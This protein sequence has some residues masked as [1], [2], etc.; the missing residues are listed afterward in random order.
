MKLYILIFSLVFLSFALP[1]NLFCQNEEDT[2]IYSASEL[3]T[4]AG[5]IGGEEELFRYI[6]EN[7]K[8][9]GIEASCYGAK[10]IISFCIE[11]DSTL[12]HFKIERGNCP[13]YDEA[14]LD[15]LKKMPKWTPG[16]RNDKVV[17][18]KFIIPIHVDFK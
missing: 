11:K 1:L 5:F 14:V 9:P 10:V 4:K 8:I 7:L 3:T 15:L 6:S 17:R 16:K 13:Y 12:T 18:S 2:T